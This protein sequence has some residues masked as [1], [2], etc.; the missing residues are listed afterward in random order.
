MQPSQLPIQT[1]LCMPVKA[2]GHIFH[3]QNLDTWDLGGGR[4]GVGAGS[5]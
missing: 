3:P 4:G 5:N 1:V 2:A